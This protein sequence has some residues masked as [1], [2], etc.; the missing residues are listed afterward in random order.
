M[1]YKQLL[2]TDSF[3]E[4][5]PSLRLNL[6]KDLAPEFLITIDKLNEL[7]SSK[8]GSR[9]D[10][11]M[12][13]IDLESFECKNTKTYFRLESDINIMTQ[14]KEDVAQI[15]KAKQ[16]RGEEKP[17]KLKNVQKEKAKMKDFAFV[18]STY[19]RMNAL[20]RIALFEELEK[21]KVKVE[22]QIDLKK[23]IDAKVADFWKKWPKSSFL[24]CSI[25]LNATEKA[26]NYFKEI[27]N[28]YSKTCF[29][30]DEIENPLGLMENLLK[31]TVLRVG[32]RK[33]S[34]SI[35][36]KIYELLLGYPSMEDSP[37]LI[38]MKKKRET[39]ENLKDMETKLKLN[40]SISF[41]E[42][43]ERF[44]QFRAKCE[45][46]D[47]KATEEYVGSVLKK[48]EP[49]LERVKPQITH[50]ELKKVV[51]QLNDCSFR[52]DELKVLEDRL[53]RVE[54]LAWKL[55]EDGGLVEAEKLLGE[56]RE[57]ETRIPGFEGVAR[58]LEA[59]RRLV[60]AVLAETAHKLDWH[61]GLK[62]IQKLKSNSMVD[63]RQA[64]T[65][66]INSAL[67][68]LT[69]CFL[70]YAQKRNL[71]LPHD[72]DEILLQTCHSIPKY[73]RLDFLKKEKV[74]ADQI[75]LVLK[76][77]DTILDDET[78]LC[79]NAEDWMRDKE[80]ELNDL[81]EGQRFL[82]NVSKDLDLSVEN[83]QAT[84]D[85]PHGAFLEDFLNGYP[86]S[87]IE[88]P[89]TDYLKATIIEIQRNLEKNTVFEMDKFSAH[90]EAERIYS[91]LRERYSCPRKFENHIQRLSHFLWKIRVYKFDLLSILIKNFNYKA[92]IISRLAGRSDP[93][94]KKIEQKLKLERKL[95]RVYSR[96]SRCY[97]RPEQLT[98]ESRP[99]LRD[100]KDSNRIR[101]SFK[102]VH[103]DWRGL[104]AHFKVELEPGLEKSREFDL[105]FPKLRSKDIVKPPTNIIFSKQI[106]NKEFHDKIAVVLHNRSREME[107][108][109]FTSP[110]LRSLR[111]SMLRR[112]CIYQSNL[113]NCTLY[114]F[115]KE[116]WPSLPGMSYLENQLRTE[117]E[118]Y[119]LLMLNP[120]AAHGKHSNNPARRRESSSIL[121]LEDEDM[122][123]HQDQPRPQKKKLVSMGQNQES[124]SSERSEQERA[125]DSKLDKKETKT[126]QK[127]KPSLTAAPV[128]EQNFKDSK[129]YKELDLQLRL[130][131]VQIEEVKA[132]FDE[133][134]TDYENTPYSQED[135]D[136]FEFVKIFDNLNPDFVYEIGPQDDTF[137][138]NNN[139]FCG[140]LN[141]N[142]AEE[143]LPQNGG[144]MQDDYYDQGEPMPNFNNFEP[145]V[146]DGLDHRGYAQMRF[147]D[148]YSSI[149]TN[150]FSQ[151]QM[152]SKDIYRNKDAFRAE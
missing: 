42:L 117:T 83:T 20:P 127:A 62:L 146:D 86:G 143:L 71:S 130:L 136:F 103:D 96:G 88:E 69:T 21:C 81:R 45:E 119:C 92:L 2:D 118:I 149:H 141:P 150:G 57:L 18:A 65:L 98:K 37:L 28:M 7:Y 35:F 91:V 133:H 30:C 4:D 104:K 94:L 77:I 59:D 106:S 102:D 23:K 11:Q 29:R 17:T 114:L 125:D 79:W 124:T 123:L 152:H 34:Y 68:A 9:W 51:Q 26:S 31:A 95:K 132:D 56:Y 112:S 85:L 16:F 49:I 55:D 58:R 109:L 129:K 73:K 108:G 105:I 134:P 107:I 12:L 90:V 137:D 148:H 27:L 142:M 97:G 82:K 8:K 14:G 144:F 41:S 67:K 110:R 131:S 48:I 1:I 138:P 93:T 43:K 101:H 99:K 66:L 32:K 122:A 33:A 52:I 121:D 135:I 46:I 6:R 60:K 89:S 100:E 54:E 140:N 22:E 3:L 78:N 115:A 145:G 10:S 40:E 76:S 113:D 74:R 111:K 80:F 15:L 13:L 70:H 120:Q 126:I 39:C 44:T 87:A 139:M 47:L 24:D 128:K 151:N 116:Q 64:Q 25:K 84:H 50:E 38:D 53:R 61:K 5:I 63:P 72:S 19:Q 36:E 75:A 147:N